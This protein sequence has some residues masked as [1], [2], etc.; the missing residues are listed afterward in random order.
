MVCHRPP[1]FGFLEKPGT[2]PRVTDLLIGPLDIPFLGPLTLQTSLKNIR[3]KTPLVSQSDDISVSEK[4]RKSSAKISAAFSH[5][6]ENPLTSTRSIVRSS[7]NIPKD[8]QAQ[9]V[10]H[11]HQFI[12]R[13]FFG[14]EPPNIPK[15]ASS[16]QFTTPNSSS[17]PPVKTP[18]SSP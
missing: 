10:I 16:I 2:R 7:A 14:A 5:E 18:I 4:M 17:F 1:G 11:F 6:S 9:Y 15:I 12:F 13:L 8:S 3:K